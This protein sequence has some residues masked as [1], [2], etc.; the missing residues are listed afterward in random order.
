VIVDI[1]EDGILDVV[2]TS[3]SH[4]SVALGKGDGTF[5][6]VPQNP[7]ASPSAMVIADVN[8]DGKL[9]MTY[10]DG[11]NSFS[12]LLGNGDGTLQPATTYPIGSSPRGLVAGDFNGDGRTDLAVVNNQT[13][14]ITVLLGILSPVLSV[15]STHP[16]NFA[17]GG[18]A[19]Y[20]IEVENNGP[21]VIAGTVTVTDTP[22]RGINC[23]RY[24]RHRMELCTRY[25]YLHA[26]RLAGRRS[27][28]S[29]HHLDRKRRDECTLGGDQPSERVWRRLATCL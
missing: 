2:G 7:V 19:K 20:T 18:P 4:A 17:V 28:L 11:N 24:V 14:N 23:D 29:G 1:N 9:D 21:G 8:G 10:T 27:K 15:I 26:Q 12:V 3:S 25:A 22:P 16:G 5:Q 6:L 13:N